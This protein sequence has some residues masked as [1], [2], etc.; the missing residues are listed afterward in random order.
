MST[1]R[2][3][4]D[5]KKPKTPGVRRIEASTVQGFSRNVSY[6]ERELKQIAGHEAWKMLHEKENATPEWFENWKQYIPIG[7]GCRTDSNKLLLENPPR[8]DDW[9]RWTVEYHNG[10][11]KK[12]SREEM[13]YEDACRL[14]KSERLYALCSPGVFG[15][16]ERWSLSLASHLPC[17]GFVNTTSGPEHD[18]VLMQMIRKVAPNRTFDEVAEANKILLVS[19][20]HNFKRPKTCK[21]VCVVHGCCNYTYNYLKTMRNE[22]DYF[23]SISE[24]VAKRVKEW[25]GIDTFVIHNGVD[26]DRLT[27]SSGNRERFCIPED[28]KV[29]GINGRLTKEKG[30][31]KFLDALREL[32]DYWGFLIGW[33]NHGEVLEYAK[34]IGV[35]DRISLH[36]SIDQIGDALSVMDVYVS[37]SDSEGFGLSV[38]EALMFG[39]PVVSTNTGVISDLQKKHGD[40]GPAITDDIVNGVVQAKPSQIDLSHFTAENMAA[41]WK[42]FLQ[43]IRN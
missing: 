27:N 14:W 41:R 18:P 9:F 39:L 19:G 31:F 38:M 7:C 25:F 16:I 5:K 26:V 6:G 33:G 20:V 29:M 40:F 12:L 37:P 34:K 21:V 28:R 17:Y 2:I 30:V 42:S 11:N 3:T 36:Y 22:C 4:F 32:N 13:S 24:S 23:V 1:I 15:G 43:S 10:V 35:S 8:F